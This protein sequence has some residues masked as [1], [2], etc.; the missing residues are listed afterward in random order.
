[1]L[2]LTSLP[3]IF[4]SHKAKRKR[5]F[6][7]LCPNPQA[8]EK[9]AVP[10]PLLALCEIRFYYSV[11]DGIAFLHRCTKT[12]PHGC[13]ANMVRLKYECAK[14][15]R[16][17]GECAMCNQNFTRCKVFGATF[18]QKGSEKPLDYKLTLKP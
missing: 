8:F 10:T 14:I 4:L 1:M 12:F 16:S 7:G 17:M 6:Y 5:P 3:R 13:G 15:V 18:F 9:S 11:P 2:A